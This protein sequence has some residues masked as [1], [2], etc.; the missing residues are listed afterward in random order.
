MQCNDGDQTGTLAKLMTSELY[1]CS[2]N[3]QNCL[4]CICM[5]C[6]AGLP[7]LEACI[8]RPH[9]DAQDITAP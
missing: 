6:L 9:R 2:N 7:K 1:M 4:R 8:S 5:Q 3:S